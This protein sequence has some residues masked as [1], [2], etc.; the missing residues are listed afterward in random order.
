MANENNAYAAKAICKRDLDGNLIEVYDSVKEAAEK[1]G[2]SYGYLHN[3][4]GTRKACHGFLFEPFKRPFHIPKRENL[5]SKFQ[6]N[7]N[8]YHIYRENRGV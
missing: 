2:I 3:R 6:I 5:I 4:L 1:N 7:H 8:P